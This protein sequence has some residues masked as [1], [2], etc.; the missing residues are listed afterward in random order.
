VNYIEITEGTREASKDI[1][2]V[3]EDKL[4]PS[5]KEYARWAEKL[6]NGIYQHR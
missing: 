2:L 6:S 4:H 3:A 5:K 1:S